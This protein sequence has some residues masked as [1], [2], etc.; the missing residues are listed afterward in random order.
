MA[1]VNAETSKFNAGLQSVLESLQADVT[2][3]DMALDAMAAKLNLDAGVTD[4]DYAGA[5]AM[6]TTVPE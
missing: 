4:E 3:L 1:E 5:A 2:A 6:T